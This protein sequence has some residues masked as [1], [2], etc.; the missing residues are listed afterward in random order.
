MFCVVW[1]GHTCTVM[2]FK[3]RFLAL[4]CRYIKITVCLDGQTMY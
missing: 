1:A 4:I 3:M 2:C